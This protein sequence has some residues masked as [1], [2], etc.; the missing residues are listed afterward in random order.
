MAAFA[1]AMKAGADGFELDVRLSG[2]GELLVF[3]DDDLQRLCGDPRQV[4]QL[5]WQELSTMRVK[6]EPIPLLRDVLEEFPNAL[7]N[8]EMK[9]HPW[10]SAW[11]LASTS[12]SVIESARALSRVLVSSFDPRLLALI[13][14]ANPNIPRALLYHSKQARPLRRAWLARGLRVAA[15]H[16]EVVMVTAAMVARAH[17]QGR[18]LNTWTVDEPD[19][20]REL[21]SLGVDALIC[22]DPGAALLALED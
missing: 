11:Q 8:V 5:S 17:R 7:V 1:A 15:M 13:Q 6:G 10:A 16:P 19:R 20:I 22:N 18:M 3:H 4:Q 2:S 14:V 21:S 12:A 9:A